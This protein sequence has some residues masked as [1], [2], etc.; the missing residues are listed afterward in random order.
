LDFL[1]WV[2]FFQS[3]Q[4]CPAQQSWKGDTRDKKIEVWRVRRKKCPVA[5]ST[6]ESNWKV[7]DIWDL[8]EQTEI[9][10]FGW[11][12]IKISIKKGMVIKGKKSKL[13]NKLKQNPIKINPFFFFANILWKG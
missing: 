7:L 12:I 8:I 13:G 5:A 4:I 3:S 6:H 2:F 9:L 10:L 11:M 1:F